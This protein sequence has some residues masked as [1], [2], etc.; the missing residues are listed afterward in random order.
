MYMRVITVN[1]RAAAAAATSVFV[2]F[3]ILYKL[4]RPAKRLRTVKIMSHD[5]L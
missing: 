1:P 3:R 4:V 2:Y 5:N